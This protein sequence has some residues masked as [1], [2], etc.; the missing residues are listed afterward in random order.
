MAPVDTQ[1]SSD[2]W[3]RFASDEATAAV[4]DEESEEDVLVLSGSFDLLELVEDELLM[5][6]PLVPFHDSCPVDVKLAV[7][8]PN[9]EAPETKPNPFAQL[10]SLRVDKSG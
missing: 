1:V 2:R 9:F 3:F 8:D 7:A 10:A 6:L 5:S 4:L